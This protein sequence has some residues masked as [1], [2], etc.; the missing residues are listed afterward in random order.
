MN[1]PRLE[2]RRPEGYR[3]VTEIADADTLYQKKFDVT[4]LLDRNEA[5]LRNRDKRDMYLIL[6]KYIAMVMDL[7]LPNL[8]LVF[9]NAGANSELISLIYYSLSFVNNQMFPHST[10]FVDMKFVPVPDRKAAI[11]AE[12]IV[13]Y[14]S[15]NPDDDQTVTCYYDRAGI[16]RILE[17]Q[18]DVTLKFEDGDCNTQ[19][20]S[21]LL[22][23]IKLIEQNKSP[24]G[25]DAFA[26]LAT[27]T[28][29][30]N[31]R[32]DER[33]TT[34][35]VI[36]LI[37]FTN[38]YLGYH[39]LVSTDFKQYLEYLLNHNSHVSEIA[40]PNVSNLFTSYFHF[41]VEGEHD[42]KKNSGLV[43]KNLQ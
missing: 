9:A 15:L 43:F 17:K 10:R 14:R 1:R 31:T 24:L 20:M 19:I 35:F 39:K 23:K 22:D 7:K 3:T 16:L 11:P 34:Q 37:V 4:G 32:M 40:A 5:Y 29:D 8:T 18:V 33:Y 36:L 28:S 27:D 6:S 38:A 13:F 41:A 25:R 42:K 26:T 21:R 12:P 30:L 2:E